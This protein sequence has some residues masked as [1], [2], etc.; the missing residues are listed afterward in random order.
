VRRAVLDNTGLPLLVGGRQGSV[1]P[2]YLR[3]I[4]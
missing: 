3:M 1:D 4:F 2:L